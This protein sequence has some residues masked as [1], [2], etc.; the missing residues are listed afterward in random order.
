MKHLAALLTLW[1][2]ALALTVSP[3]G[4]HKKERHDQS[5]AAAV[6]EGESPGEAPT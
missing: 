2:L 5:A 6:Q 1:A 3:A 4:A